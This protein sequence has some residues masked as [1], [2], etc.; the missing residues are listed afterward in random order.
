MEVSSTKLRREMRRR[1]YSNESYWLAFALAILK[2]RESRQKSFDG[3][4]NG[5]FGN[6]FVMDYCF[7][8][9]IK[10]PFSGFGVS[11]NDSCNP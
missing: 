2:L 10:M 1:N 5:V 7:F 11:S 4:S 6:S 9:R 8:A 3:D